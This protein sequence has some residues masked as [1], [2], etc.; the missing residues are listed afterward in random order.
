MRIPR[1][2]AAQRAERWKK[3]MR[4]DDKASLALT[5]ARQRVERVD[6]FRRA[7]VIEQQHMASFDRALDAWN[8]HNAARGGIRAQRFWIELP[9]VKGDGQAVEPEFRSPVQK[10]ICLVRNSISRVVGCMGVE[11]DFQH[12]WAVLHKSCRV[13]SVREVSRVLEKTKHFQ[14]WLRLSRHLS[15]R[16]TLS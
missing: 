13:L 4:R 14:G 5:Q 1:E 8:E 7:A 9:V 11:V 12:R 2:G 10:L 3:R 6:R 15:A 16:R